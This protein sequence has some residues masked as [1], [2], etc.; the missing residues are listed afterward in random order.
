MTLRINPALG[1]A[2]RYTIDLARA[3]I[4]RG[5]RVRILAAYDD[6]A[7]SPAPVASP[8]HLPG[9]TRRTRY[10]AFLHWLRRT[11]PTDSPEVVHAMLAVEPG[12]CAIYHPHA[13]IVAQRSR[14][15]SW[16]TNPRRRRYAA[17]EQALLTAPRPPITI[18]LS[19][20][21]EDTL[22]RHY[23]HLASDRT[24]RL[25]NGVDL[26]RFDP[27]G[28]NV[29]RG[30]LGAFA[31]D[32]CIALFVG[33]DFA[34]KGLAAVLRTLAKTP[35][36]L[37]LAIAGVDRTKAAKACTR[38]ASSLG[39]AERVTFLGQRDTAPLYRSA[40]F[41]VHASRH[42]PCSL[43]TLEALA[44]GLPIIG[45]RNDGAMEVI[46]HGLH[47]YRLGSDPRSTLIADEL[48]DRMKDLLDVSKRDAMR[49]ACLDLRPTLS[50][51]HHVDQLLEIYKAAHEAPDVNAGP[52]SHTGR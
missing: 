23:P 51:D 49:R 36:R 34:R 15:L 45:S 30:E 24:A 4:Q 52:L 7:Q 13:G 20:Y 14:W 2:E 27:A 38:L 31:A 35:P 25:F 16:W 22:R 26:A 21:V 10:D 17:V 50:W 43:A 11:L 3:L 6:A 29:A 33:N 48:A 46:T 39:V 8:S 19:Q 37:K 32:D 28:P 41:A 9:L 12:M 40:D 1:G 5:H 18:T 42:D 47:G 44:S